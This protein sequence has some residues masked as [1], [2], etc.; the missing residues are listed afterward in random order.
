MN[1]VQILI[2]MSLMIYNDIQRKFTLSTDSYL[3]IRLYN[4]FPK[5]RITIKAGKAIELKSTIRNEA[6]SCEVTIQNIN[7]FAD[8]L[9]VS[10]SYIK[11]LNVNIKSNILVLH[12]L[13][14][15][16]I[17]NNISGHIK[18]KRVNIHMNNKWDFNQIFASITSLNIT[19]NILNGEL[20]NDQINELQNINPI[21]KSKIDIFD[22][23]IYHILHHDNCFVITREQSIINKYKGSS[24]QMADGW[25]LIYTGKSINFYGITD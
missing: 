3:H 22:T 1:L 16:K 8:L 4:L 23:N 25:Y 9:E 6:F 15:E 19:K 20:N 17:C 13:T 14:R 24:Y 7:I 12:N 10:C 11:L 18:T 5:D 2:L 21:K